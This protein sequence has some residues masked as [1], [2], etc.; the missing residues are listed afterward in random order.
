MIRDLITAWV[1][2]YNDKKFWKMY[3]DCQNDKVKGLKRLFL[4]TD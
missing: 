3:M 2:R 1:I 4:F